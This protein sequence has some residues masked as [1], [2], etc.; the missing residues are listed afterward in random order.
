MQQVSISVMAAV[1]AFP[2]LLDAAVDVVEDEL[3]SAVGGG[4]VEEVVSGAPNIVAA[5]REEAG[6][7]VTF[8]VGE[9]R[10]K[11]RLATREEK[12]EWMEREYIWL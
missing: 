6:V 5:S 2:C 1:G 4:A 9:V 3:V 7:K 12:A 11:E 8:K 10:R